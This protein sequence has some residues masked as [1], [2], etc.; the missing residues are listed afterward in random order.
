MLEEGF[1]SGGSF[2]MANRNYGKRNPRVKMSV[3][4]CLPVPEEDHKG[5]ALPEGGIHFSI[6][7][8]GIFHGLGFLTTLEDAKKLHAHLG[9]CIQM[10]EK[11]RKRK[12]EHREHS[13]IE[14]QIG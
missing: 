7:H 8:Q 13:A 12:Q 9:A 2:E 11:E 3:M 1:I 4:P 10:V 6:G 5:V 14:I